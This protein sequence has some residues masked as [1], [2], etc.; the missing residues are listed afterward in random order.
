MK[1]NPLVKL[2]DIKAAGKWFDVKVQVTSILESATI[3]ESMLQ[4]GYVAD[5]TCAL[6]FVLW[7][8]AFDFGVPE[9]EHGKS[10]LLKNVVTNEYHGKFSISINSKSEVE[11]IEDMGL[12]EE[13]TC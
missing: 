4:K 11:E 2:S 5:E 7:M 6:E 3:P 12:I 13:L 8:K 9:L 10:Y 1:P